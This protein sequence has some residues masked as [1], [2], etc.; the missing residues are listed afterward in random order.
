MRQPMEVRSVPGTSAE[1]GRYG[2][3]P[4]VIFNAALQLRTIL[5]AL[6]DSV[7]TR[8]E[9]SADQKLEKA[10]EM[11]AMMDARARMAGRCA[12]MAGPGH[13]VRWGSRYIE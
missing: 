9:Q 5:S 6:K 2:Q 8:S 12:R 10:V 1:P 7:C 13:I 11:P 3:E 4:P